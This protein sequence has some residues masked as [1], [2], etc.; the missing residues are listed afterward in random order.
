MN[1]IEKKIIDD[2][3]Q[4][5]V[6]QEAIGISVIPELSKNLNSI[7]DDEKSPV[8]L[9]FDLCS[10]KSIDSAGIGLI[11]TLLTKCKKQSKMAAIFISSSKLMKDIKIS[12]IDLLF[13]I[14]TNLEDAIAFIT[15][16][17]NFS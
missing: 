14:Y 12:R 17:A 2:Y 15:K 10:V 13:P 3:L 16:S 1:I 7:L 8:K 4:I 9:I 11:V 6:N 5:I